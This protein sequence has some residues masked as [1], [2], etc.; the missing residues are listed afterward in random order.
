MDGK[1]LVLLFALMKWL[2]HLITK[3]YASLSGLYASITS[4]E[5]R[6]IDC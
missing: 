5:M 6:Y 3:I 1:L 4:E 2:Q